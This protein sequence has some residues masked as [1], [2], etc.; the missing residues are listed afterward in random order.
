MLTQLKRL[1]LP[2]RLRDN[3]QSA[4]TSADEFRSPANRIHYHFDHRVVHGLAREDGSRRDRCVRYLEATLPHL[5]GFEAGQ[6]TPDGG[7]DCYWCCALVDQPLLTTCA[8]KF[9]DKIKDR[10]ETKPGC[11]DGT[12]LHVRLDVENPQISDGV[13][14][15]QHLAARGRQEK[16]RSM[17]RSKAENQSSWATKSCSEEGSVLRSI[18][19]PWPGVARLGH[20]SRPCANHKAQALKSKH[21]LRS[22]IRVHPDKKRYG[23]KI[24]KE[25]STVFE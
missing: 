11:Y 1:D 12:D 21:P 25:N 14:C 16:A 24:D 23:T 20:Y 5:G 13:I 19:S 8:A 6:L 17:L 10:S 2:R 15:A 9:P 4:A 18:C 22:Q 7:L 3:P